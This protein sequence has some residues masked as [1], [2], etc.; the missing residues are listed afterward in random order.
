MD[1]IQ[2]VFSF[3]RS[4][5]EGKDFGEFLSAYGRHESPFGRNLR[6]YP[7]GS[8]LTF[9]LDGGRAVECQLEVEVGA[10]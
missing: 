7:R 1:N 2:V 5:V 10:N 6:D 8:C 3:G 4:E 9:Y